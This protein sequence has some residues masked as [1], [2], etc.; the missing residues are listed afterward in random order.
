[1]PSKTSLTATQSSGAEIK[2][3]HHRIHAVTMRLPMSMLPRLAADPNVAYITPDRPVQMTEA[4]GEDFS[5]AVEADTAVAQY[6][7]D[8]TGIGVAVI[9]SG[10]A[11]HPDLHNVSGNSRVVYSESFVVGDSSA[12]DKYGHG[13]HVAGLIGGTGASS[14]IANGYSEIYAGIAPNVNLINLRAL[15]QN[16]GGSDSQVIAAIERAIALKDVY[17]IRVINMSLG[18]PVFE[19]YT[20]DPVNKAVEDAW[21]A[22]IVVVVAAGNN[23]RYRITNGFATI[24]AP[25]NDPAVITVGATKTQNT[26]TRVDDA[27]ASYSSK[28]PTVIDHIVKPDLVAPG[29]R[30]V[31]LRVPGSTMDTLHPQFEVGPPSGTPMYYMLSGTSMS[32][33]IVSGAVALML[34]Q[35][36]A[37]TPDQVKARLM[38]TAWKSFGQY[39]SSRDTGG[40]NYDNEYDIF[41]YGAGYLDVDAALNNK[42]LANGIALSPTAIRNPDGSVTI[43]NTSTAAFGGASVVWGAASLIWGNSVVWG[44]NAFS[45]NSVVWGAQSVVW[46]ASSVTGTS[47]VWGIGSSAASDASALSS[48]DDGDN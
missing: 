47:V 22:G 42:D 28:G 23:G 11:D 25:G 9:D 24:A 33:P 32:T 36:P 12:A 5:S 31:S 35:N 29:N 18:R 17:N 10:I 45:S 26:A 40:N 15:N 6:P 43:V 8:G 13:T 21:K 46:G 1:M 48:D 14:G 2:R 34:Q 37:L 3:Q 27:I 19:N 30:I 44:I 4:G 7:L 20:L 16:G 39:S 38:K 41:T